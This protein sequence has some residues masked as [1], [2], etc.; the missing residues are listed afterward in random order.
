MLDL[1][2]KPVLAALLFTHSQ[3][4]RG[5]GNSGDEKRSLAS[6]NEYNKTWV[7]SIDPTQSASSCKLKLFQMQGIFESGGYHFLLDL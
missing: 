5:E 2:E 7:W 4:Y 1:T 6:P 3:F